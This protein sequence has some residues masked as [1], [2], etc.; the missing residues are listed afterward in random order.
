[1][2][3]TGLGDFSNC[4]IM[5]MSP[6]ECWIPKVLGKF[7]IVTSPSV[8]SA[9]PTRESLGMDH[10]SARQLRVTPPT[11]PEHPSYQTRWGFKRFARKLSGKSSTRDKTLRFTSLCYMVFFMYTWSVSPTVIVHET[12]TSAKNCSHSISPTSKLIKKHR[13]WSRK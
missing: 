9:A 1:M 3:F 12:H 5:G 4:T 11:I 10:V 7:L 8:H 2:R 6:R 13:I